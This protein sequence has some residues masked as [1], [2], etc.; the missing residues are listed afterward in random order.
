MPHTES[1]W[2]YP[3]V[4]EVIGVLPKPY[5]DLWKEK[6][7]SRVTPG[8]RDRA[9]WKTE[10]ANWIGTQ[11]HEGVRGLALFQIVDPPTKRLYGMLGVV[12]LWL[13]EN[14]FQLKESELKVVH[15]RLKYEGT[16]DAVGVLKGSDALIL[17]DW[18]TSKAIHPEM[19]MQLAAYAEAYREQTGIEIKTGLIVLVRK[20][21]PHKMMIKEFKLDK[22]TL[23]RF[24]KLRKVW[25]DRQDALVRG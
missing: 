21:R 14:G 7:A 11:F 23:N 22:R 5:L 15:H 19:G 6:W 2:G 20:A 10:C 8:R 17:V 25:Q 12:E 16:L 18:K 1:A 24:L 4:T 3:S 13:L 9:I